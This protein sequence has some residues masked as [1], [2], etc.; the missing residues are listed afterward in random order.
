MAFKVAVVRPHG[1]F[2]HEVENSS[3]MLT[4]IINALFLVDVGIVLF[5]G[6][7]EQISEG[8]VPLNGVWSSEGQLSIC[9]QYGTQRTNNSNCK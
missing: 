2:P 1:L 9:S 7:V 5:E 6:V 4:G 3:R 8:I